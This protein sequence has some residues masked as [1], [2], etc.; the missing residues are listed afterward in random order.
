MVAGEKFHGR[1]VYKCR[2]KNSLFSFGIYIYIFKVIKDHPDW[3]ACSTHDG[4]KSHVNVTD[5][6]EL[7]AAHKITIVKEES[8]SSDTNQAYDQF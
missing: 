7:F 1:S 5:A 4:F 2:D 8:G 3:E 6:L